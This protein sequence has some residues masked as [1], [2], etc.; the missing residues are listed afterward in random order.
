MLLLTALFGFW[1]GGG[2]GKEKKQEAATFHPERNYPVKTENA[3]VFVVY[4]KDD[5]H[6]CERTLRSVFEQNYEK[7]RVIF[8]DDA[9]S[10]NTSEKVDAFVLENSQDHR[11]ISI[12]NEE[13]LGKVACLYRALDQLSDSEIAIP[14]DA[15]DWL[16]QETFLS[17][18]NQAYQNPDVWI[19]YSPSLAYPSYTL[20]APALSSFYAALFKQIRLVDLYVDGE[21]AKNSKSWM[22]PLVEL[23]GGRCRILTEPYC[24]LNEARPKLHEPIGR[25]ASYEHL[26]R[27]PYQGNRERPCE[28]DLILFSYNRPLQLY[29]CLESIHKY[30]SGLSHIQVLYRSADL[31]YEQGYELVKQAFP[32][33]KF[34]G[35]SRK[36]EFKTK[37]KRMIYDSP[38]PYVIFGVDDLI[39]K[40]AVDLS[41]CARWIERTGAYA[42]FLRLGQNITFCYMNGKDQSVPQNVQVG[43]G[44]YAYDFKNGTDDWNFPN[45]LD[46]TLYRKKD[47]KQSLDRGRIETPNSL[48]QAMAE[49]PPPP[50]SIGLFFEQSKV[51]NL[52][53]NIVNPTGSPHMNFMSTEELLSLFNQ[54]LKMNIEPFYRVENRSPHFEQI[55]EFIPR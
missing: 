20:R 45:N 17:R 37:L 40:D 44:L 6:W 22:G 10:D 12:R 21:F 43:S 3:F 13:K 28:V 2:A 54:G 8:I 39:V 36:K 35:Q 23:A 16:A 32:H 34:V 47:I 33:V 38:S 9:S 52:P 1:I 50:G 11:V 26:A 55:P 7:F 51:V 15:K 18:L 27:F 19:T 41:Q 5:A 4:A 30:F 49:I 24:F 29:T 42:F 14:I 31:R 25:I 46:M 53:L 48:E